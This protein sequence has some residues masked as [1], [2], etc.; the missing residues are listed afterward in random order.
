M[1]E[2]TKELIAANEKLNKSLKEN[3]S[4]LELLS[5]EN[6]NLR[7]ILDVMS[8]N[9]LR[10]E[11]FIKHIKAHLKEDEVVI[12]K[13]CNKTVDE[14]YNEETGMDALN[15]IKYNLD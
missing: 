9:K 2:I 13:I 6:K 10:G 5:L 7:K 1:Y 8:A 12:C 15:S 4:A 11:V 3:I 14:I